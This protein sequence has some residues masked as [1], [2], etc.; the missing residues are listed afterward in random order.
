M[1]YRHGAFSPGVERLLFGGIGFTY[2]IALVS[3]LLLTRLRDLAV[4][5]YIQVLLD[6]L[7]ITGLILLTGGLESPLPFLYHLAILNAAFLLFRRG[8]LL[9]A[10]IG[11]LC[12]GG[13]VDLLYYGILPSPIFNSPVFVSAPHPSDL[14]LTVHLTAILVSFYAIAFLG[15]YLTQRLSQIETLLAERDVAFDHLSSLYKGVIQNLESGLFITNGRGFV[16]YAN[17]PM[18]EIIGVSAS[19]L[20]GRTVSDIFP[21]SQELPALEGP[22]EFIFRGESDMTDRILRLTQSSLQDT[23]GN[24]IGSLYSVQD[25]TSIKLLEQNLKEVQEIEHLDIRLSQETV[26]TFAGIIGRSEIMNRVYQLITKVAKNLSTVL[27]I[28]ESGTGKELVARAIHHKGPRANRPFVPVNCGAIPESLME[29]ELFGYVKGAFTG[30]VNNRLGLFREADGGTIF[31]DEIGELPLPLQVKLLRVLQEREVTP[32]GSN[33][34]I[35]VDV[36]VIAAT[37]R[38]LEVDIAA[39]RFREDLFY[40]LNVVCISLPPLRERTG[41]LPLLIHHFLTRFSSVNGKVAQ[42]ISPQAMRT[43][44]EYSYPG[45]IRELENIIHHAVTMAEGDTIRCHDLPNHLQT[46]QQ[47]PIA[48]ASSVLLKTNGKIQSDDFFSRGVTLDAELETY[49]QQLLRAALEKAGGVQKKAAKLL[50]INY[51]SLRHRLQKYNL[52]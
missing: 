48:S 34:G 25:I 15:S 26:E 17:S 39:G 4:F 16:E 1:S 3:G 51:R 40:R 12:Y 45:N 8:A 52:N 47:Y 32:I 24:R 13:T 49:E 30:A 46:T 27:V 11:A 33:K 14:G 6:P 35:S 44:L 42:H 36:R 18:S 19:M 7:F 22:Y 31:L 9:S 50:R 43:L 23:Y 5:S 41:D 10:T 29:S 2:L 20:Q 37:N 38:N 21:V 28:G